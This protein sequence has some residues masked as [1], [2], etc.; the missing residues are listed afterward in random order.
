[1]NMMTR[2]MTAVALS[3]GAA[4]G[5]FLSGCVTGPDGTKTVKPEAAAAIQ[6][7]VS[8]GCYFA[9]KEQP[10]AGPWMLTAAGVIDGLAKDAQP[11]TADEVL[12][13]LKQGNVNLPDD[14]LAMISLA[15]VGI[16]GPLAEQ[17]LAAEVD[18][19]AVAKALLQA[20][21]DGIRNGAT[22]AMNQAGQ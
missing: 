8:V 13:A 16:Y 15:A 22:L 6:S 7:G 5:L 17:A 14:E 19:S 12:A 18:K 21:A 2:T 1:M 11:L 9:V 3:F 4:S 20:L 10:S